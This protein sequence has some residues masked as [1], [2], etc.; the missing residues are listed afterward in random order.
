MANKSKE[1]VVKKEDKKINNTNKR[2]RKSNSKSK[3]S[4]S[5]SDSVKKTDELLVMNK[6]NKK[7]TKRTN[8]K[9]NST[10]KEDSPKNNVKTNLEYY[11][12]PYSYNQTIVKVLAQTP[13]ILFVYWDISNADIDILKKN[14]GE[15]FLNNTRPF[16]IVKNES[17]NYSFE[18]EV[19]DYANS[20][21]LHINDSNCKYSIELIRKFVNSNNPYVS[22]T[23]SNKMDAPNDHILF[24]NINRTIFF[25]NTKTNHFENK[26]IGSLVFMNK[27]NH[28]YNLYSEM[29]KNEIL[30]DKVNGTPNSSVF[31]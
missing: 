21:Y 15:N 18:V 2:S 3:K 17:M 14:Y 27:I 7:I 29:Y 5:S 11:D 4:T 6:T 12:L 16:L 1:K 23:S 8:S 20:W 31:K 10:K 25:K 30:E 28:I 19:N 13:S 24:D 26:D 22:I 9:K